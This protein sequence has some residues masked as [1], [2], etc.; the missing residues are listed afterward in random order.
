M[1]EIQL[2]N[3]DPHIFELVLNAFIGQQCMLSIINIGYVFG[4]YFNENNQ[5]IIFDTHS[6]QFTTKQ[7]QKSGAYMAVFDNVKVK[8]Y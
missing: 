1:G 4:I 5:I 3:I 6:K 2:Q 8:I 7:G